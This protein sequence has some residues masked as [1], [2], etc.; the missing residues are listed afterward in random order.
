MSNVIDFNFILDEDMCAFMLVFRHFHYGENAEFFADKK[1]QALTTFNKFKNFKFDITQLKNDEFLQQIKQTDK[2][3]NVFAVAKENYTYVLNEWQKYAP[4]AHNYVT[5]TLKYTNSQPPIDVYITHHS[6]YSM[7]NFILWG[8]RNCNIDGYNTA[9]LTHEWLHKIEAQIFKDIPRLNSEQKFCHALIEL[10]AEQTMSTKFGFNSK[11]FSSHPH[12]AEHRRILKPYFEQML[13]DGNLNLE[14]M[15][16][17]TK[18]NALQLST[19][20]NKFD[21][22]NVK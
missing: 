22:E 12:L 11:H 6:G 13:L 19:L 1:Q 15:F 17:W 4:L 21:N 14:E 7:P 8:H 10:C 16:I 5:R 9:Y 20:I 3:K 18:E 2:F